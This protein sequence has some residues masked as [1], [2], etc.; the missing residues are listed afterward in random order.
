MYPGQ[1]LNQSPLTMQA[2]FLGTSN[3][4]PTNVYG[5][6]KTTN[7]GTVHKWAVVYND[8]VV[9]PTAS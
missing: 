2:E 1:D 9:T 6:M 5:S 3:L 8:P 7:C 4:K